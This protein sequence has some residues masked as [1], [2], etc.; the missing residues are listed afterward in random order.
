MSTGAGAKKPRRRKGRG[1]EESPQL[2]T[3]RDVA[4]KFGVTPACI[5]AWVKDREFPRPHL[6]I[7]TTWFYR[8]DAIDQKLRTGTWPANV[9]LMGD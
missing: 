5:R 8:A 3:V 7:G 2:V 1:L 6:V 9:K 4:A